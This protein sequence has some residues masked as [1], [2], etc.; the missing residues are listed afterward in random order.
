MA[1]LSAA[2]FSWAPGADY[3]YLASAAGWGASSLGFV[4]L[5]KKHALPEL[6]A[7]ADWSESELDAAVDVAREVVRCLR[8]RIFWPPAE[9]PQYLDGLELLA[10][11]SLAPHRRLESL[12]RGAGWSCARWATASPSASCSS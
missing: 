6:L 2:K 5:S 1:V 11:D 10:G 4:Q 12:A 3:R 7:E 8:R 9:P